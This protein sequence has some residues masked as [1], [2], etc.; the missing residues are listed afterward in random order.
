[1]HGGDKIPGIICESAV[2]P[3]IERAV[4]MDTWE[5]FAVVTGGASAALTGLLFVA[6]SIRLDVI[7]A[8][9]DL[10]SRAAQT[11]TLFLSITLVAIL[12]AIPEQPEWLL[13]AE[14]SALAVVGAITLLI[15]DRRAGRH[16]SQHR[17]ARVL[18]LLSP[19]AVTM[20]LIGLGGLLTVVGVEWGLYLEVPAAI[21]ALVGGVIGAWLFMMSSGET[22]AST[23][24]SENAARGQ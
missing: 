3:R 15:L 11:L 10:R 14:L 5:E 8:S 1:M 21:A 12:F 2:K 13:G 20:A 7:A 24:R 4:D 17:V 18:D 6:V 16:Q 23:G 19:N 22:S 9:A